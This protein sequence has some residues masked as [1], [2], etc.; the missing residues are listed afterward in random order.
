MN[1]QGLER[2]R[3]ANGGDGA[4]KTRA[5]QLSRAAQEKVARLKVERAN[6]ASLKIQ[7]D[8]GET[9]LR[10]RAGQKEAARW[11]LNS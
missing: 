6:A 8:A 7:V 4:L 11:M 3:S 10:S 2:N 1:D 5:V 9:F